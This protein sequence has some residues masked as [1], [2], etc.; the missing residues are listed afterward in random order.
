MIIIYISTCMSTRLGCL[1]HMIS[2]QLFVSLQVKYLLKTVIPDQKNII[3]NSKE[4]FTIRSPTV[5]ETGLFNC[6][7][8]VNGVTYRRD[9]IVFRPGED[10]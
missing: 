5:Y 6:V 2:L 1:F 10:V 7:T 8:T 3:W 9:F 4:G